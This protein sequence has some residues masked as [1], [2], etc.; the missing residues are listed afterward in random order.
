MREGEGVAGGSAVITVRH[1]VI[2][3]SVDVMG[4]VLVTQRGYSL[5]SPG[6]RWYNVDV[7]LWRGGHVEVFELRCREH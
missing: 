3:V 5:P 2:L 7:R 6:V 1:A 4:W